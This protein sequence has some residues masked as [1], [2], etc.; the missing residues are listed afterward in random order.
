MFCKNTV[1]CLLWYRSV[2]FYQESCIPVRSFDK[3]AVTWCFFEDF[4][5]VLL[6]G[7]GIQNCTVV[8]IFSCFL[9][10]RHYFSNP[11]SN[12]FWKVMLRRIRGQSLTS[13]PESEYNYFAYPEPEFC[14]NDP[15]QCC[16]VPT[17]LHC[18]SSPKSRPLWNLSRPISHLLRFFMLI[19]KEKNV[20]CNDFCMLQHLL[21]ET[22]GKL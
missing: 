19:F 17:C 4:F 11:W 2:I 6:Y 20:L 1:L 14:K 16:Q 7:T 22:H 5:I 10:M 12:S 18:H 9:L 15:A 21:T 3:G 13:F 8:Y